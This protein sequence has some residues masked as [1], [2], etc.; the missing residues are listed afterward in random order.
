M[1]ENVDFKTVRMVLVS[2]L[3]SVYA[4][5]TDRRRYERWLAILI[6][7]LKVVYARR[8]EVT[9][10]LAILYEKRVIVI[11][12]LKLLYEKRYLISTQI[13]LAFTV[14]VALTLAASFVGWLSFDRVSESQNQVNEISVPEMTA[15]FRIAQKANTLMSAGPELASTEDTT[16]YNSVSKEISAAN[17]DLVQ[18]LAI[19]QGR[20]SDEDA[21][22]RMREHVD[23]LTENVY[24]IQSGM[25]ESFGRQAQL[26]ALEA[27]IED[28]NREL[29]EILTP[30]QDDLSSRGRRGFSEVDFTLYLLI[31]EIQ[32][33]L[34]VANQILGSSFG[35]TDTDSIEPLRDPLFET[36]WRVLNNL[37]ETGDADLIEDVEPLVVELFDFGIGERGSL[38]LLE[39]EAD[40]LVFQQTLISENRST[41]A[42]LIE[43]V[44]TFVNG[45]NESVEASVLEVGE[46]V[47]AGRLLLLII[48]G[49][50]VCGAA[51]MVWL[52]VGRVLLRRLQI[53]IEWMRRMA[54]GD[55]E[56]TVEIGGR[57]EGGDYG[58]GARSVPTE[59]AR[60]AA[61]ESGGEDGGGTAR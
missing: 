25:V 32:R 11:G 57:D 40:F 12:W 48:S 24:T 52:L 5:I 4:R 23:V 46:A 39:S 18:E 29:D 34:A 22:D 16:N 55:L 41:A 21:F 2:W 58:R 51:L 7:W 36:K 10:R 13:Y 17:Q 27:R 59:L 14:A 53:M 50:S 60:S 30:I 54:D 8:T 28:V 33:D 26:E 37:Q 6:G 49:A 47:N 38:A 61:V 56:A 15:S 45:A 3:K 9:S 20:H 19:L 42:S 44:E 35:I 31:S 1:T 43:D